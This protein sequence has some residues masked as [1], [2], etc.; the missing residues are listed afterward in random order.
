MMSPPLGLLAGAN[1][2]VITYQPQSTSAR[3]SIHGEMQRETGASSS[4]A[5]FSLSSEPSRR[6]NEEEWIKLG[7][8]E[9]ILQGRKKRKEQKIKRSLPRRQRPP[10]G[11]RE[12]LLQRRGS[13]ERQPESGF[14]VSTADR[15]RRGR[16]RNPGRR[17]G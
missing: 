13:R 6:R 9:K 15:G 16:R 8:T 12:Q 4:I 11:P 3:S 10:R 1:R 7:N 14:R 2:V 5:S 17:P